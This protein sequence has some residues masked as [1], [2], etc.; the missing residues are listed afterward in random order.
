MAFPTTGI[1]DNFNRADGAL[2][3]GWSTTKIESATTTNLAIQSNQMWRSGGESNGYLTASQG[4]DVEAYCTVATKP[5]TGQYL[6]LFVR[7]QTPG[8]G[9]WDGY[10]LIW[11]VGATNDTYSLRRYTNASNAATLATPTS[12]TLVEGQ[13]IGL[14]VVGSTIRAWKTVAGVWQQVGTDQTDATYSAA[15]Q[16]G[17][18]VPESNAR[19]DD[20]GGGTVVTGG[21]TEDGFVGVGGASAVLMINGRRSPTATVAPRKA[22]AT[23]VRR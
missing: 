9:G 12:T 5:P 14:E 20:F 21:G 6:G 22:C 23:S 11:I 10:A 4:P 2:G 16:I 18:E 3:G 7:I 8:T 15:G 17:I 13:K 1:L 19:I